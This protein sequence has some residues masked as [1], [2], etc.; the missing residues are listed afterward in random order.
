MYIKYTQDFL[1][2][3]QQYQRYMYTWYC[4]T[5]TSYITSVFESITS[6]YFLK[7]SMKKSFVVASA[8]IFPMHCR[9]PSP[10]GRNV[11]LVGFC[12]NLD[13]HEW[14]TYMYFRSWRVWHLPF[15]FKQLWFL[16][17][18]RVVV[19]KVNW[20]SYSQ[21]LGDLQTTNF[22]VANTMSMKDVDWWI[23]SKRFLYNTIEV[24]NTINGTFR[25][26]LLGGVKG[27]VN[28]WNETTNQEE[29]KNEK[30]IDAWPDT[31]LVAVKVNNLSCYVIILD[32]CDW[33]NW[34]TQ[35]GCVHICQCNP[36]VQCMH[37]EKHKLQGCILYV[38][39]AAMVIDCLFLI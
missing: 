20:D 30:G 3:P 22:S 7:V 14:I 18:I 9:L 35:T 11:H 16:P 38:C 32:S 23:Q 8:S 24:L 12:W 6:L 1:Y 5:T 21:S 34:H 2:E 27:K 17:N 33:E 39:L 36:C 19:H 4:Q 29:A 25:F 26:S 13:S 28:M 31:P 15:G 37:G 10:N